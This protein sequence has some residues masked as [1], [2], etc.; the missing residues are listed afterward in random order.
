MQM[1]EM[2][3]WV[4]EKGEATGCY[5]SPFHFSWAEADHND[6]N[7]QRSPLERLDQQR[8]NLLKFSEQPNTII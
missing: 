7:G 2:C 1:P 8:V 3:E 5:Q 4:K 6:S